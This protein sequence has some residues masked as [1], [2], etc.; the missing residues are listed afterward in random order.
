MIGLNTADS[1]EE[2]SDTTPGAA[3]GEQQQELLFTDGRSANGTAALEG[4]LHGEQTS[5]S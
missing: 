4:G 1:H 3:G 5:Q 2:A